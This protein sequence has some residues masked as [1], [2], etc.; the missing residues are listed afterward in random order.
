MHWC[1]QNCPQRL[2][3]LSSKFNGVILV[4]QRKHRRLTLTLL[5]GSAI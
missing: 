1:Q 5:F 3:V 2:F 4:A